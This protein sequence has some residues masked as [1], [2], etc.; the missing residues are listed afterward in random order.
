[1]GLVYIARREKDRKLYALKTLRGRERGKEEMIKSAALFRGEGLVWI[2]LGK[3]RNVV[4]AFWFDLDERYRPF[5]IMEYVEGD[6][7]YGVSLGNWLKMEKGLEPS[8]AIRFALEALNGL[9]Y[10]KRKVNEDLNVPFIHRDIKPDNLLITRE[11][12]A[13]VTDFGLVMGKGGTPLYMPHE[14]WGGE[15]VE[16]KT[17]VYALGCVLYEMIE[18]RR[19]FDDLTIDGLKSKH[20]N[21]KPEPM[22]KAC[23]EMKGLLM[24]CLAKSPD[25]RPNF[26][27]LQDGLQSVY[28]GLTGG[29]CTLADSPEP[30]SAE[31]LNAR[32]SG[33]DELG[34]YEKAVECYNQAIALDS[35]D[36]RFYMNRATARLALKDFEGAL[37]DYQRAQALEPD[38]VDVLI[39]KGSLL[40]QKGDRENALA[41]YRQAERIAPQEP[42]VYVS[43]GNLRA[44]DR[45]YDEAEGYFRK[46]LSIRSGLAEAHL[47]LGNVRLCRED[48]KTAEVSYQRAINQNPLYGEAYL[49]LARL[50][51]LMNRP[52]ERD[53]A[54]EMACRL[55]PLKGENSGDI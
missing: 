10:A 9:G 43:L 25:K 7:R 54:I 46:A 39:G 1:M 16:E 12:T 13:K 27:E 44:Q 37:G 38:A 20:L 26:Q 5:L 28:I 24:R 29:P 17:D 31:D 4:Q 3:H 53:K 14:Q 30:L 18:G 23:S 6:Q 34:Y 47:G 2:T 8:L 45:L 52:I 49:N 40:V 35:H 48:Y 41:C 42:L 15:A 50:C 11:G 55:M 21:K 51:Q 19:P 22:K 33:F 36:P 32:G